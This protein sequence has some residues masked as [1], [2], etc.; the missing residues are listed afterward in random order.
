MVAPHTEPDPIAKMAHA[1]RWPPRYRRAPPGPDR[2]SGPTDDR[3]GCWTHL[4]G[5]EGQPRPAGVLLRPCVHSSA[6]DFPQPARR[7]QTD[8]LELTPSQ[9]PPPACAALDGTAPGAHHWVTLARA[10]FICQ[11]LLGARAENGLAQKVPRGFPRIG[12]LY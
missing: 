1:A 7:W 2:M 9:E 5:R 4:G 12:R 6:T 3:T 10:D 11:P 8:F